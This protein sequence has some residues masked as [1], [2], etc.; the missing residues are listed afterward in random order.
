MAAGVAGEQVDYVIR[1]HVL[2]VGVGQITARQAAARGP[3]PRLCIGIAAL[4][5]TIRT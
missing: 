5:L 3:A 4:R 2:Q 1:G